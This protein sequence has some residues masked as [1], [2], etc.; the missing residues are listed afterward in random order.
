MNEWTGLKP[1]EVDRYVRIWT[2][3]S[4]AYWTRTSYMAAF[5]SALAG[6]AFAAYDKNRF[7]WALFSAAGGIALSGIWL[8]INAR[9]HEYV[10]YWWQF[11][12]PALDRE[13]RQEN[14]L[15]Y[16]A[17]VQTI[18]YL[19][20]AG[21]LAIGLWSGCHRWASAQPCRLCRIVTMLKATP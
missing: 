16:H 19:F 15:K 17:I 9:T 21:F 8:V 7:G 18:P 1:N 10:R 14:A 2:W 6:L 4:D 13:P 5:A 11:I 20:I 3:Q 12:K